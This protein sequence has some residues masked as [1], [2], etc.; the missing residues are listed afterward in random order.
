M[1]IVLSPAKKLADHPARP[2]LGGTQPVFLDQAEKL[3]E[4][5]RNLD[6]FEIA[7]LMNISI[8]LADLNVSRYQAWSRP[9]TPE[10]AAPALFMFRGDVY[11]ELD[12]D[13]LTPEA[14]HFAQQHLRILSGLYGLLRPLDLIQPY[15]L[16]MGTRLS[17]ELG[18]TLYDF[19]GTR[20][21]DEL[22]RS[23]EEPRTLINLASNEY[24]KAIRPKYFDGRIITVHFK[25][26]GPKGY[27][28]V[29]LFAKRAR[30]AMA[31][32]ALEHAITEPE[33]LLDFN[34]NG[35]VFREDLSSDSDWIFTR[36]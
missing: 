9:F 20:I 31:R 18:R 3:V 12:A 26:A 11:Q 16:E 4:R 32:F 5:L 29:G 27:R 35:Y 13:T 7:N 10:N 19:W 25:E 21:T 30:G 22:N 36:G 6:S 33:V 1:L 28:T 2:P 24:F 17:T 34:R 15:R 23:S 8:K 14:L